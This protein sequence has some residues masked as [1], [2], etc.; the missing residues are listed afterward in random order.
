M[1]KILK[2]CVLKVFIFVKKI[3]FLKIREFFFKNPQKNFLLC[4]KS[5][6]KRRKKG[7]K[8]LEFLVEVKRNKNYIIHAESYVP[9]G[10]QGYTVVNRTMPTFHER[11]LEIMLTVP[12]KDGIFYT[13]YLQLQIYQIIY[14]DFTATCMSKT[15]NYL[16]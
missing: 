3:K 15:L 13:L 5:D 8:R 16:K 4:F 14:K 11:S 6:Q 9:R 10:F 12:L 1:I 7:A 2:K